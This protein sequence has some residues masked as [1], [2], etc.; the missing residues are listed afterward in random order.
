VVVRSGASQLATEEALS[1]LVA[2]VALATA[3]G[4]DASTLVAPTN[5]CPAAAAAQKADSTA[6]VA[7]E[8]PKAGQQGP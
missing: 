2:A 7:S 4:S 8:D 5:G 6:E 1:M 3:E